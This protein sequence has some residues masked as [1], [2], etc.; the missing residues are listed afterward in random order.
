MEE[1]TK[2]A[3]SLHSGTTAMLSLSR[4]AVTAAARPILRAVRGFATIEENTVKTYKGFL[5]LRC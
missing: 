1:D 3:F 4:S 5:L 2:T